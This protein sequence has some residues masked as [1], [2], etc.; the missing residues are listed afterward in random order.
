MI[1]GPLKNNAQLSVIIL[2]VICVALWL[3]TSIFS[4]G[5]DIYSN[6]P[7][8]I[9][10]NFLFQHFPSF[11]FNQLIKLLV[12]ISGAIL[13]N[14][15]VISQEIAS[16]NNYLPAFFY[17]LFAFS[18]NS[19]PSI[20]PI[21]FANLLIIPAFYFLMESYREEQALSAFFKAGFFMGLSAFFYVYYLFLFPLAFIS[22]FILRA[23]HWREWIIL[24]IGL[25]VPTYLYCGLN[26]LGTNDFLKTFEFIRTVLSDLKTP[27]I[28]EYHIAFLL[29][30][31]LLFVFALF[32]NVVKGFGNKVKTKKTKLIL[33]WMSAFCI[34]LCFYSQNNN[35]ILMPCMIPLS[36]LI[37]DYL[38]EIRQLKVS[39]TLLTLCLGAF[40]LVYF[41]GIGI[42]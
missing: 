4:S 18:A 10:Y 14:I 6:S 34:S 2:S 27:L 8:H 9:A 28:S 21:L 1:V 19:N 41:H 15:L 5:V 40:V 31:I 11:W 30:V 3:N 39:N 26:Y 42:L 17:I 20:E 24:F 23:F 12:I 29:V 32:Q 13:L 36:I 35:F 38:A 25:F 16:K 37:G 33:L 7:E 22:L